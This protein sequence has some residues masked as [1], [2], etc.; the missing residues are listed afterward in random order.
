[1]MS[2]SLTFANC[3]RSMFEHSTWNTKT[4]HKRNN[5]NVSNQI[6]QDEAA[7]NGTAM[8]TMVIQLCLM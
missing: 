5:T 2:L 8:V 7:V 3:M 4:I 6:Y 1:M